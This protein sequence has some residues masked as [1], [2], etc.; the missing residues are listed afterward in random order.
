MVK[1]GIM[2]GHKFSIHG[3]KVDQEKIEIIE[4]LSPPT[5][6]KNIRSFLGHARFTN[7]SSKIS[8]RS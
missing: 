1:E 7:N 6:I 8:Q 2:L 4:K 3:I 5:I